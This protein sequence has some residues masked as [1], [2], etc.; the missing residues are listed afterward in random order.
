MLRT[1]RPRVK[2][3]FVKV[4]PKIWIEVKADIP[5]EQAIREYQNKLINKAYR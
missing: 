5:D 4:T 3:K 2:K 1:K